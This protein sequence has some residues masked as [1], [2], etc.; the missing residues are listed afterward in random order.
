M[1]NFFK[2]PKP[3]MLVIMDGVGVAQPGPGNAVTLAQTPSLNK[4]WPIYPHGYLHASGS[5]VGLPHGTDGNSEVGHINI[6]AGKVV[7]QDLPR[8]DNAITSGKFFEDPFLIK[9]VNQV[10]EMKTRLH[11]MGCLGGGQ[12]HS[13]LDHIF[14]LLKFCANHGLD[15]E[16]V[17]LHLFTDGR[18]S[19][20]KSAAIYLEQVESEMQRLKVGKIASLIGRYY[21]MD[22][23]KRWD[24]TQKAYDLIVSGKGKKISKWKEAVDDSYKNGKTDEYFEPYVVYEHDLPLAHVDDNDAVIFFNFRPDRALELTQAFEEEDFSAWEKEKSPDVYFV[25]MTEYSIG[26]PKNITFPP[27]DI[28]NPIG[29]VVS[30]NGLR[31]LRIAESEKFPHVTYFF[32]GGNQTVY[33]GEDR[34]EIPSVRD[35]ATYDQKPEMSIEK[36]T[37]VLV[38]KIDEDYYDF[39]V[40]NFANADMVGHTGVLDAAIKAVEIVDQKTGVLIEKVLSKD[41]ALVVIADHGNAEEMFNLQTGDVDT[42]HSTNPVPLMIIKNGLDGR[43]LPIGILADVSPTMLALMGIQKPAEMTGRNLLV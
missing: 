17:V 24:R 27:E 36:V 31:Q 29:R 35:V 9:A 2:R 15:E 5:N 30:D 33:P 34:V 6:G 19:P 40:V 3:V 32:N 18:D 14:A 4:Y 43:E 42:K 20:P 1:G 13:S 21:A 12:V 16:N 37:E 41:G 28:D 10:K 38:K 7:F 8:I 11:L 25:G 22:R 26:F 23:D 39:I